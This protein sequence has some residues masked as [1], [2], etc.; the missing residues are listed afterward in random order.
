MEASLNGAVSLRVASYNV[1]KCVGLDRRRSPERTLEVISEVEADV[2]ALQEADRRLGPRPAAL[3][4]ETIESA[5]DLVPVGLADNQVS[6]GWHG[7]AMLVRRD[8][9]VVA[10]ERLDLP[11]LE[12]RGA[13]LVEITHR[14]QTFRIIGTHLGLL[15]RHRQMQLHAI[16]DALKGRPP[17]PTIILG[18][19]NEWSSGNG[20]EPLKSQ[21]DVHAPGR[22]F[23]AARP[24]AALDRIAT[25]RDITLRDAGV[26]QRGAAPM[27]SDHLPVWADITFS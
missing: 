13:V 27:A 19:F 6:L 15:R 18:D 17:L 1:R 24:V 25:S 8:M 2:V 5:T 7:N 22:S 4:R 16:M 9:D 20:M 10:T 11:G 23:H 12:P 14:K 26:H 3:P 21:F